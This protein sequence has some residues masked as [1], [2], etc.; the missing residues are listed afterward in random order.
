MSTQKSQFKKF[1]LGIVLMVIGSL[2]A[3]NNFGVI[4]FSWCVLFRLWP[5][6]FIVWGVSILPLKSWIKLCIVGVAF[7]V[8]L[9]LVQ[10]STKHYWFCP[11]NHESGWHFS[12]HKTQQPNRYD[13]LLCEAYDTTIQRATLLLDAG[14]GKFMIG[15][16]TEDLINIHKKGSL[17][18]Y[19]LVTTIEEDRAIVDVDISKPRGN[20]I[21][22]SKKSSDIRLSDV[23]VW[24]TEGATP[25]ICRM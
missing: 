18:N 24:D 10:Q 22:G 14:A 8:A 16:I 15:G 25:L 5:L 20:K 3:L 19:S 13:D 2:F 9:V 7:V 1:I 6:I 17:F 23:P 11:Q 4:E 21:N 12:Q